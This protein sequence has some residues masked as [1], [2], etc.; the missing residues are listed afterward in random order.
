MWSN[1]NRRSG[2]TQ[3]G[4]SVQIPLGL[5]G[6]LSLLLVWGGALSGIGSGD[7]HSS[8]VAQSVSLS[9]VFTQKGGGKVRV[10]LLGFRAGSG[11]QELWLL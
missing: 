5:S 4:L 10:I 8:K 2:D 9:P 1:A 7:R 6:Q 11:A 3:L